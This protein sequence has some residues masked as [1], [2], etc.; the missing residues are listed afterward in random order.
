MDLNIDLIQG[1]V[2]CLRKRAGVSAEIY[3]GIEEA[4][5]EI[6]GATLLLTPKG[7]QWTGRARAHLAQIKYDYI[8]FLLE[9]YYVLDVDETVVE[10][11]VD[12]MPSFKAGS[13][14]L[15]PAPRP[16]AGVPGR[17]DL[18]FYNDH[19][20]G[21]INT[22]PALWE[23]AY[24]ESLLYEDES[25]WEFEIN[26]AIRSIPSNRNSMG[27]YHPALKY[28]EV[29]KRGKFRNRFKARYK[30]ELDKYSIGQE[31][32]YL[33]YGDELFFE[34]KHLFSQILKFFTTQ[35]FRSVIKSLIGPSK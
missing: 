10:K 23:K 18:G 7:K 20:I 6:E 31:R 9:D 27:L 3:V 14:K 5:I 35:H 17:V 11:L 29:V 16:N 19:E 1:A 21:R 2:D 26:S 32:G 34:I 30:T 12:Q 28:D 4:D 25:L 15:L 24:L 8:I 22:Q 13:I 33:N